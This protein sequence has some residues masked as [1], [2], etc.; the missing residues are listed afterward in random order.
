[1]AVRIEKG[2]WLLI[3]LVGLGLVVMACGS[4]PD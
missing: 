4:S 1:M 2:G 3:F